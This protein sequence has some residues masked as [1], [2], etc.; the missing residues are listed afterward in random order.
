M[1]NHKANQLLHIMQVVRHPKIKGRKILPFL[2]AIF[3]KKKTGEWMK[4]HCGIR[5]KKSAKNLVVFFCCCFFAGGGGGRGTF[6]IELPPNF[7]LREFC[8][9]QAPKLFGD[10]KITRCFLSMHILHTKTTTKIH[11]EK[12]ELAKVRECFYMS[13]CLSFS[14][15]QKSQVLKLVCLNSVRFFWRS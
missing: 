4:I 12:S 8:S 10:P 14:D 7:R 2:A 9:S 13:P 11:S 1:K 5:K 15:V 6:W 3:H